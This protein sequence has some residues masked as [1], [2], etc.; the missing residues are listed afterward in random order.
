VPA[1]VFLNPRFFGRGRRWRSQCFTP[2][3]TT[4]RPSGLVD[5]SCAGA[6]LAFH[7]SVCTSVGAASI[8]CRGVRLMVGSGLVGSLMRSAG[9]VVAAAST[10]A[11]LRPWHELG[12]GSR[13][14][15]GLPL[16]DD[17][18]MV[19]SQCAGLRVGQRNLT[20]S[21]LQTANAGAVVIAG[22]VPARPDVGPS[23]RVCCWPRSLRVAHACDRRT[24]TLVGVEH[25]LVNCPWRYGA[26]GVGQWAGS[27]EEWTGR[28]RVQS[29][30]LCCG[31]P[32]LGR[33]FGLFKVGGPLA[34]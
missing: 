29:I 30:C 7:R 25:E 20:T 19:S 22:L 10:G 1:W 15:V 18:P 33:A 5:S 13:C 12:A 17:G 27:L 6:W 26:C 28:A 4:V 14:A 16:G 8:I 31:R 32:L 21:V 23:A 24:R 34:S 2:S 9:V 11:W 3:G